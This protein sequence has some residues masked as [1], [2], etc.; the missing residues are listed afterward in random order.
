[1]E[2][3]LN[4]AGGPGPYRS[5]WSSSF[6]YLLSFLLHCF[7][8]SQESS[9]TFLERFGH[10]NKVIRKEVLP[11]DPRA[12]LAWQGFK[13]N[14]EEQPAEYRALVITDLHFKLFTVPLTNM[15]T[16][17]WHTSPGPIAQSTPPHQ[18]FSV[19]LPRHSIKCLLQVYESHVVSCW[20]IDTS[21][22]AAWQQRLWYLLEVRCF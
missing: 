17:H 19:A 13:H 18:V 1:M 16:A 15:D 9:K 12:E 5:S 11:G 4:S 3:R 2:T 7:F 20:Q 6:L 14:D 8:P 10:D 21:L 22:A